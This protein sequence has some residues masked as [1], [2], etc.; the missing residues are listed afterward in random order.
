MKI[1]IVDSFQKDR[2]FLAVFLEEYMKNNGITG[3]VF[4]YPNGEE[5]LEAYEGPY[6]VGYDMVFLDIYMNGMNGMEVAKRIRFKSRDVSLVFAAGAADF[7]MEGYKV[8]ALRYLLKPCKEQELEDVLKEYFN[9]ANLWEPFLEI[10]E[11]CVIRT[12]YFRDIMMA[13]IQGHYV[14]FYMKDE[15]IIKAR[16]TGRELISYVRDERFLEC[17]RNVLVNLDY[18]DGIEG[19]WE[20]FHMQDGRTVLIQRSRKKHVRQYFTDYMAK[21]ARLR[22][23]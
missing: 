13:Q 14:L 17:Y 18:V 7:A 8:H 9:C 11:D 12:V 1:A 3:E 4:A 5:F 22:G 20:V 10:K 21:S 2:D 15:E 19:G 23:G 6:G 16:M